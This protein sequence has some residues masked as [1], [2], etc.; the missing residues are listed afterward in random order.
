[1]KL[2]ASYGFIILAVFLTFGLSFA[3]ETSQNS[4]KNISVESFEWSNYGLNFEWF[5]DKEILKELNLTEEQKAGISTLVSESSQ[6]VTIQE[7]IKDKENSLKI[8]IELVNRVKIEGQD[9]PVN[10]TEV[11]SLVDQ[12]NSLRSEQYKIRMVAKTK[13]K[14]ILSE[15]QRKILDRYF[16]EKENELQKKMQQAGGQGSGRGMKQGMGGLHTHGF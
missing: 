3:E 12:I 8:Q 15:D 6:T 1:M 13:L 14:L 5:K 9:N 4:G 2:K 7:Q 11:E 10:I 16:R